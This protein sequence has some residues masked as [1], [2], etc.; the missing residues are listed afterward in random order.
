MAVGRS[1]LIKKIPYL[2]WDLKPRRLAYETSALTTVLTRQV[3]VKGVKVLNNAC[4]IICQLAAGSEFYQLEKS[5]IPVL[6]CLTKDYGTLPPGIF[7]PK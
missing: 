3:R 4:P 5:R 6:S 1:F 7:T 2:C